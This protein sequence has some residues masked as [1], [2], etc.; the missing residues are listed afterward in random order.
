MVLATTWSKPVLDSMGAMSVE[1]GTVHLVAGPLTS[2]VPPTGGGIG[3]FY[4]IIGV[5]GIAA[6]LGWML[7]RGLGL[8][9]KNG[10]GLFDLLKDRRPAVRIP[11]LIAVIGLGAA[12]AIY[13]L[14]EISE[15]AYGWLTDVTGCAVAPDMWTPSF[16]FTFVL[17]GVL[18]CHFFFREI[19]NVVSV[20]WALCSL[21]VGFW[22]STWGAHVFWVVWVPVILAFLPTVLSKVIGQAKVEVQEAAD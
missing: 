5:L 20:S 18:A 14:V 2:C 7:L 11:A 6:M 16:L 22:L 15:Q 12:G 1:D 19:P 13:V 3:A 17:L 9:G 4:P 8:V 21:S 10:E